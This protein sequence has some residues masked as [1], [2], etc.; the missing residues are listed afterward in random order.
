MMIAMK[1]NLDLIDA[2]TIVEYHEKRPGSPYT[3]FR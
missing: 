3:P 1:V 2:D